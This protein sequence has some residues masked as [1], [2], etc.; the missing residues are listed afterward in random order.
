MPAIFKAYKI[1]ARHAEDN[2]GMFNETP[3]KNEFRI[4]FYPIGFN[5]VLI[6]LAKNSYM[7]IEKIIINNQRNGTIADKNEKYNVKI[8]YASDRT[9]INQIFI[10]EINTPIELEYLGEKEL[11]QKKDDDTRNQ[12]IIGAF[13]EDG[14]LRVYI[15]EGYFA[16][17]E[18]DFA[19][20]KIRQKLKELSY[21]DYPSLDNGTLKITVSFFKDTSIKPYVDIENT[22]FDLETIKM[23]VEDLYNS[24]RV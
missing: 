14:E 16:S 19:F 18:V 3:V 24:R 21:Y 12:Y 15:G 4:S 8:I 10:N 13:K 20:T 23:V 5:L 17:L 6:D 7:T 22:G 11:M 2:S 1:K 9:T